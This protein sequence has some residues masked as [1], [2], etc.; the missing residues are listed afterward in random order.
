M[1]T[2]GDYALRCILAIAYKSA[3]GPVAI[4]RI[5]E[6]EHLPSDYTEQLMMKLRHG[7]LVKSVRGVK[8]GYLL[9]R[10]PS[11]ITLKDV[12]EAVEGQAFKVICGHKNGRKKK[13]CSGECVLKGVWMGLKRKIDG[14]LEN[15]TIA[16]L[17]K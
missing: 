1:T 11:R 4:S 3:K 14:Y 15:K 8:G 9:N 2:Q 6:E 16:S 13:M 5:V 10:H 12:L 7:K 17:M